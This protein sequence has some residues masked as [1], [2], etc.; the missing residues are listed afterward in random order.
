MV[1]VFL[2]PYDSF[3]CDRF[4]EDSGFGAC[5]IKRL[6][7]EL[8]SVCVRFVVKSGVSVSENLVRKESI[9]KGVDC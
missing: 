8:R 2:C 9:P 1:D 4:V 6:D 7:G 5:Y 3:P